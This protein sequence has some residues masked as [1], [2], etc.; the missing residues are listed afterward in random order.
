MEIITDQVN[1]AAELDQ[2]CRSLF[3]RWCEHRQVLPLA[4][5][6]QAWPIMMPS[7]ESYRRLHIT[8]GALLES[9]QTELSLEEQRLIRSAL[10]FLQLC[11]A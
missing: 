11:F 10:E 6:M 3:D 9:Y 1:A 7:H 4:Y 5:L 8:L 2:Y